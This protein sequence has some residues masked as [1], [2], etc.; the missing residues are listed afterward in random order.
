MRLTRPVMLARLLWLPLCLSISL[1]FFTPQFTNAMQTVGEEK[2]LQ[3]TYQELETFAN[4]L[5]LVQQYY[6]DQVEMRS[7][8]HGAVNGMLSSLDPHSGYMSPEDFQELEEETTGSFTGVGI[9]VTIRDGI[10]TAV[11]PIEGTPA[12]RL[13]IKPGD[14]IMRIDGMLT[15]NMTLMEATK[16]MRGPKGST[17]TLSIHRPQW[18]DTRDFSLVR[19]DIPVFS[20]KSMEL[21]PGYDYIRISN[22]QDATT[23][24]VRSALDV[25][26]EKHPIKGLVLDLRN[27][28]GGLLDQA[29]KV[30]DIF[31]DHGVI[32]S[33]RGRNNQEQILYEAHP[34][35]RVEKYPM[36]VLINGGS[37]SGSEIVAGALQDHKRARILGTTSFGKGSVQT[38]IPLPDGSGI[39]LTTAKYYTPS[40]DSI[41]AMGIRPDVVVA[42]NK[43]PGMENDVPVQ[44]MLREKDL[45]GHLS[46]DLQGE[47]S[48]SVPATDEFDQEETFQ[49][50]NSI[51][52]VSKRLEQDNQL[53]L[54]LE[55][56]KKK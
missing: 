36:V 7:L 40:G 8:M 12:D 11:A 44:R 3:D 33:T 23:E 16:K 2:E 10:L 28:P 49:K 52:E 15:K 41:Q 19:E 47:K 48:T 17:I 27:N 32:V 21:E 24:D 22:F 1:V 50:V 9:E 37:A 30:A 6:V 42:L 53:R 56:L 51:A 26:R 31:L 18:R 39:R 34:D 14:R 5:S 4:V 55:L 45:P 43:L 54:A 35:A 29:I 20:V 13:G 46:N 25:L 38:I